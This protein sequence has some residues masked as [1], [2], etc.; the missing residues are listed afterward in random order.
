M[1]ERFIKRSIK[2]LENHDEVRTVFMQEA[3]NLER[4]I[5]YETS[6]KC[7]NAFLLGALL[8]TII[9][10]GV[11]YYLKKGQENN[12]LDTIELAMKGK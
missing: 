4:Y 10:G 12:I 7:F 2:L 8:S 9:F 5:N 3:Q 11:F 1:I 6:K